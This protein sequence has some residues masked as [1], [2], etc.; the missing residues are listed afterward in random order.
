MLSLYYY[1]KRS[2][3]IYVFCF[4]EAGDLSAAHTQQY[5]SA[6]RAV[7]ALARIMGTAV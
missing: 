7:S 3:A 1:C 6:L 5:F 2:A 4:R